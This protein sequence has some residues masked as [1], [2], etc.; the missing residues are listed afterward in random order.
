MPVIVGQTDTITQAVIDTFS[1]I[2]E[3]EAIYCDSTHSRLYFWVFTSNPEYDAALMDRL[4]NR[5]C[6]I[7]SLY[8]GVGMQFN[9]PPS[10]MC[11]DQRGVV[12]VDAKLIWRREDGRV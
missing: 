8:M 11:S 7:R 1:A 9:Y 12:G 4:I 2:S 5:E 10:G 6:V 3:V